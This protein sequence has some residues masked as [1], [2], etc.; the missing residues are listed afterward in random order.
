LPKLKDGSDAQSFVTTQITEY[1][2]SYIKLMHELGDTIDM[3]LPRPPPELTKSIVEAAH[4]NGLVAVGHAFSYAGAMDLLKGGV[5]GL[6]HVFFDTP[7]SD[8]WLELMK[9][10]NVHCNP[11]LSLAASQAG[12]GDTIQQRFTQSP[13]AQRMLFDKTPRQNLGLSAKNTKAS[14]ENAIRNTKAMYQAGIPLI[15][16]S[17]CAGKH[18]GTAY[19]LGVHVEMRLMTQVLGMKPAEILRAATALT[20]DRFGF[21]DRGRIQ[22]GKKADLALLDGDAR[23]FLEEKDAAC[24]PIKMV[25]RDGISCSEYLA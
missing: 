4:S 1:G 25:W 14:Y 3:D 16:G 19:G 20:A 11:T 23:L 17:D 21:T 12:A 24:L 10:N 13:F 18:L 2:A 5:D 22:P 6:T 8:D 7:P 15:V 9:R